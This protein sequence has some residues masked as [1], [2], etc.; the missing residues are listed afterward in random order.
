MKKICSI[1]G[2]FLLLLVFGFIICMTKYMFGRYFDLDFLSDIYI[3]FWY[4][5]IRLCTDKG[6]H[7]LFEC[8]KNWALPK[9]ITY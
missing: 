5:K 6:K 8:A 2:S 1:F 9:P 4:G 7:T 3:P